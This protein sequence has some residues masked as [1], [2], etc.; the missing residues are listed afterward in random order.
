[1]SA[2]LEPLAPPGS[3]A[4]NVR[5]IAGGGSTWPTRS[6][7]GEARRPHAPASGAAAHP[8]APAGGGRPGR[9]RAKT[10][11]TRSKKPGSSWI[12]TRKPGFSSSVCLREPGLDGG[13]GAALDAGPADTRGDP[14]GML[15]SVA[16]VSALMAASHSALPHQGATTKPGRPSMAS[17]GTRPTSPTLEVCSSRKRRA[18]AEQVRLNRLEQCRAPASSRS[19]NGIGA[20]SRVSRRAENTCPFS[21]SLGP[22]SRRSGT[23]RSSHSANFQPGEFSSLASSLTRTPRAVSSSRMASAFGQH[24]LL[25]VAAWNRHDDH[26]IRR[27]VRRQDEAAVVAVRHDHAA[28]EPRRHAPRR[29]PRVLQRLVAALELDL[30]RLARS[31]GR[32]CATCRPAGPGR[33]PSAPRSSRCATRRRTS[34]CRS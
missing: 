34:R 24:G 23:P 29:R 17:P 15:R 32:G 30:E 3:V 1:M 9:R 6:A 28:D 19:V 16:C 12:G 25:P 31:S 13:L 14:S 5:R 33:P 10:K 11:M 20:F 26:L 2:C 27:D 21:M 8:D 18:R 7:R 4:A 22:I